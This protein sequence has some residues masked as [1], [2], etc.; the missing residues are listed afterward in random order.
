LPDTEALRH[1][2]GAQSAIHNGQVIAVCHDGLVADPVSFQRSR[3]VVTRDSAV[4][5]AAAKQ[6]GQPRTLVRNAAA[7]PFHTTADC[8]LAHTQ[9]LG[10]DLVRHTL[11]AQPGDT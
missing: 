1:H 3:S 5:E 7:G 6:W 4:L 9:H 8:L 10:N 2:A 11:Q